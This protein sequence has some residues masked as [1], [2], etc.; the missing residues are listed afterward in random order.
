MP[1]DLE[2]ILRR[3][4]GVIVAYSLDPLYKSLGA[5]VIELPEVADQF[6]PGTYTAPDREQRIAR[7][8]DEVMT[9]GNL[10]TIVETHD[11]YP[12][13]RG[14]SGP[15]TVT[16]RLA[17][18]IRPVRA[19]ETSAAVMPGKSCRASWSWFSGPGMGCW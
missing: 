10:A 16:T 18:V 13:Q 9:R 5:I 3:H 2:K 17:S 12:E 7:I 15:E 14:S 11:L 6:L 8:N 19:V 4:L 1:V